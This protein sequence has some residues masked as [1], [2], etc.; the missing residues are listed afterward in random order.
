MAGNKVATAV[1]VATGI[2]GFE[3]AASNLASAKPSPNLGQRIN[4]MAPDSLSNKVNVKELAGKVSDLSSIARSRGELVSSLVD[5]KH[6]Q[7]KEYDIGN[8]V[9]QDF[10]DYFILIKLYKN[11]FAFIDKNGD[12]IPE[13]YATGISLSPMT[14]SGYTSELINAANNAAPDNKH[15]KLVGSDYEKVLADYAAAVKEVGNAVK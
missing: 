12:G 10:G 4:V 9:L 3:I 5:G 2:M 6:I 11:G 13:A 14:A 1:L 7:G 15:I 8:Y